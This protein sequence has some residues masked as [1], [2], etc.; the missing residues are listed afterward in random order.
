[1]N[2]EE[3]QIYRILDAN[4]NRAKEALRVAEDILRF[5]GA[6]SR[7]AG[8]WKKARHR[9]SQVLLGFPRS[10]AEIVACRDV[11]R[12]HGKKSQVRDKRGATRLADLLAA[13]IQRAE[14]A[15]RVLE[16]CAK[17]VYPKAS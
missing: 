12:D 2:A 16:E 11:A 6:D 14:E 3:K 13:N 15:L 7:T 10:Y 17:V 1:M 8:A 4:Y 9:L 5:S